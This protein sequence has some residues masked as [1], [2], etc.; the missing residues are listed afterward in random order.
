[1]NNRVTVSMIPVGEIF[2]NPWNPNEQS[3]FIFAKERESIRTHGFI[4]PILVRQ[5]RRDEQEI[6]EIID[7]EHRW[8]AAKEEGYTQIPANNLG[9]VTDEVAKQLTMITNDTR[10]QANSQKQSALLQSL[11]QTVP[12]DNL[13][14]SLPYQQP[15]IMS[16]I[17]GVTAAPTPQAGA[18]G[19]LS[20]ST[21]EDWTNVKLRLPM[22][23]AEQLDAQIRRFKI[24]LFPDQP[25]DGVSPVQ[26][27]EAMIQA[28]AQIPDEQLL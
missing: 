11:M 2:A 18:S 28:L 14:R 7:G 10:G 5:I 24:R 8:R 19:G 16:M 3:D 9:V 25:P 27:I 21:S 4:D 12:L 20:T 6:Y 26:P 15:H 1:M 17:R 23:V 22:A 13:V